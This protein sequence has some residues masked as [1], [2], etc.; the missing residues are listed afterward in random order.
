VSRPEYYGNPAGITDEIEIVRAI[1][2]AFA[3]RDLEG[4]LQ[5]LA[6]DCEL[7][8]EGTAQAAGREGPYRGHDGLRD[9]FSDV[10]RL[11]DELVLHADDVRAVPG[12]VIVIGHVTGR[13]QGLDVRRASVWTWRVL[14]GRAASV[15]AADM[16]E[17]A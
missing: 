1:Y 9:Y 17:L 16:G 4:M 5:F 8:L 2:D 13:K 6:P 3:R 11:W 15:R 7:W 10:E 12:S 14:G